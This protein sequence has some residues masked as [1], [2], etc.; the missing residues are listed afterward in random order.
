M[1]K[2]TPGPWLAFEA[3]PGIYHIA[4]E[5]QQEGHYVSSGTEICV[6][7]GGSSSSGYLAGGGHIAANA[8]L[9][10]AAPELLEACREMQA[11]LFQVATVAWN[12]K[13]D[14]YWP[15]GLQEQVKQSVRNKK[16]DSAVAK[17]E[18]R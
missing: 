6:M 2:H 18:G 8:H 5:P 4:T 9:V 13:T 10:A 17:A 7:F 15:F 11:L 14:D 3:Q 16:W 12:S 1:S